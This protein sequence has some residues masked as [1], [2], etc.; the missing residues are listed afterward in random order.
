MAKRNQKPTTGNT[1]TTDT[2]EGEVM[3][4]YQLDNETAKFE[5]V[6]DTLDEAKATIE[7][8]EAKQGNIMTELDKA[9]A[10]LASLSPAE[11]DDMLASA[12]RGKTKDARKAINKAASVDK[13]KQAAKVKANAD[14]AEAKALQAKVDAMTDDE[15]LAFKCTHA[16]VTSIVRTVKHVWDATKVGTKDAWT[17]SSDTKLVGLKLSGGGSG[18]SGRS[19]PSE[20]NYIFAK[21][22]T[23]KIDGIEYTSAKKVCEALNIV[24]GS[25]SASRRLAKASCDGKITKEVIV[26]QGGGSTKLK[27]HCDKAKADGKLKANG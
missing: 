20:A 6:I 22:T 13:E 23:F 15:L 2:I 7:T 8:I 25:D 16:K 14:K 10:L 21:G 5:T 27:A 4:T 9:M 18:G 12:M 19:T 11:Q 1:A 24:V 17:F 26:V 3:T